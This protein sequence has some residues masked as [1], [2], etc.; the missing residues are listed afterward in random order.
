MA[1]KVPGL[2][3]AF[4][5]IGGVLVW[6]GIENE[7]VTAV[8]RLLAQGKTLGG[9]SKVGEGPPETFATAAAPAG[10][11][12]STSAAAGTAAAG[13]TSAH[14]ASAAANQAIGRV[15][16]APYGWAT[17]QQWA[18]LVSLW[19]QESGW[20]NLAD[21]A[22]SGAYGIAQALGHGPTNQYPAGPANPPTSS[23]AAQISWG[24]GY[25]KD[26]YGSPSAAWAHERSA[27]WY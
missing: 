14:G 5:A 27:G 22:T 16:A 2:P 10:T 18:D 21:N 26:T 13:D 1:G 25:I 4:I 8:F 17:G 23:A 24:L 19:N 9:P 3:V 6:S 7:P 15:L 12:T 11:S 20:N